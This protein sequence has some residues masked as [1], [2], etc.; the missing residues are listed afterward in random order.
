[1]ICNETDDVV[2]DSTCEDCASPDGV[3]KAFVVEVKCPMTKKAVSTYIKDGK[4]QN[5]FKTQYNAKCLHVV[6]KR[7]CFVLLTHP[8]FEVTRNVNLVCRT[9]LANLYIFTKLIKSALNKKL[10]FI[11]NIIVHHGM[12]TTA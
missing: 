2:L 6:R 11:I 8:R 9:V 7:L 5:K 3:A 1:V 10:C 4:V 12:V